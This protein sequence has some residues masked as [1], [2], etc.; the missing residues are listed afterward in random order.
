MIKGMYQ[1]GRSLEG[2]MQGI[3][4]VANNLANINTIGFKKEQEF[5][6]V[7]LNA[8]EK[9][10]AKGENSRIRQITNFEQGELS[11]TSNP[12][13]VALTGN[14]FFVYKTNLGKELSKN[15]RLKIDTEGYLCDQSG[16]HIMGKNGDINLGEVLDDSTDKITISKNGDISLNDKYMDTIL[17]AKVN[18][19]QENVR[20]KGSS[21]VPA[22]DDIIPLEDS[23]FS[24][25]QGYLEESNVN[26]IIE[27][28][29]MITMNKD[30]EAAKKMINA[31]DLSLGQ[32]N[33]IGKV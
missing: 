3:Q 25:E 20:T 13:D 29:S 16:N 31:F 4:V 24:V 2:K 10:K 28:E 19:P 27:M 8:S 9:A 33:E 7:L 12:L 1:A 30:Y 22:E 14:G 11:L 5:S 32:A 23:D 15:G 21:F 18:N 26:P 6:E 17:V